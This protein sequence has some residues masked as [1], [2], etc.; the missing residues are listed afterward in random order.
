M[1]AQKVRYPSG[2]LRLTAPLSFGKFK[3]M[4]LLPEFSRAYPDIQ[5]DIPS[6]PR[7]PAAD[8]IALRST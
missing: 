6:V 4:P 3:V 8:W 1:N 7:H 5:L 2:R